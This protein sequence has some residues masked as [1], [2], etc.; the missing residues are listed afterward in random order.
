MK[1]YKKKTALIC[2]ISGQDGS[3]LAKYL[4]KKNYKVFGTSRFLI[5]Q[6]FE[7]LRK[8]K[9]KN[10]IKIYKLN[11]IYLKNINQ[12]IHQTNPNEIYYLNSLSSVKESI[13]KPKESFNSTFFGL[14]NFLEILR[15]ENNSIKLFNACSSECFGNIKK[16]PVNENSPFNP[17]SPYAVAKSASY[18]LIRNYRKSYQL[19]LTNGILFNHESS[20]RTNKFLSKRIISEVIQINKNKKLKMIVNNIDDL[21]R[22]WGWAPEYVKAMHLINNDVKSDDYIVATGKSYSLRDFLNFSFRYF[23]LNYKDFIIEKKNSSFSI[24]S[25]ADPS[26]I[27][28]N[29]KWKAKF[30]LKDIVKKMIDNEL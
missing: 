6:N 27:F 28:N 24:N 8:L 7:N 26:K 15:K 10:R 21:K 5:N 22:D 29:L 30:D 3:Y 16:N 2:G 25:F 19:H 17:Q 23:N 11:P 20:L 14:L 18:M 1:I 12:I 4:L 9:I 13:I